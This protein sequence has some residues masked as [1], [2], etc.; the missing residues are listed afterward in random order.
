MTVSEPHTYTARW[1]F[2][3]AGPP[4]PSGTV[5][6]C[7]DRIE[8]VD[9]HGVRSPDAD[10]G[11]AA[12]VPGL[13]NAHTHLDL[14]GAR[15]VVPPT[16]SN[17]FPDWLQGV[18]AYRRTRTP[19][20]VQTDTA[21]GLAECLRSGTTLLGDISADGG[22][23]DAVATSPVRA[24]VF[25][26]L[27]GLKERDLLA[28]SQTIHDWKHGS[29]SPTSRRGLSP[30]APYSVRRSLMQLACRSELPVTI[31]WLES[32]GEKELI[33]R[34]SGPFVSFLK[35]RGVWDEGQLIESFDAA[36]DHASLHAPHLLLAHANHQPVETRFRPNTT[37]VYCP[38]T[39]AAFGH[40]PHPFRELLNRGVRVCLG[41]DSLA[42]NPDLDVLAEARFIHE[43]YPEF[44]G[45][46]L[47]RMVTLAGAESLG[48][49][50]ETGSLVA[51]KSA[52]CVVVPLPDRE[53]ADAH[54][55]LFAHC[56]GERR[57][58][59]R[60]VWRT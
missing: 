6:I 57:T 27:I 45:D 12:V 2:P 9:C 29:A 14:S 56:P 18:I 32:T 3:V 41:T 30:H 42:S 24:V 47:L 52:D 50:D 37:I 54:E 23:W 34:H 40:P 36:L 33:E 48:W 5:T 25:R 1:V 16:D 26:E 8:S 17:H 46:A 15:G 13:V 22:S 44:P 19:D 60:G 35:E 43:R 7:G 28:E 55:L 20:Q 51:G 38:R 49:E 53:A 10:F 11:N 4:L 39:H 58:L 31:H 59:F 21:A